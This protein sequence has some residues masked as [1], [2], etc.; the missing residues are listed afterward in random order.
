MRAPLPVCL[1]AL[2]LLAGC[3]QKGPLVLPGKH[4]KTP[5]AAPAPAPAAAP[6]AASATPAAPAPTDATPVPAKPD[7]PKDGQTSDPKSPRGR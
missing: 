7:E 1:V 3:G 6:D 5:V 2:A 4:P